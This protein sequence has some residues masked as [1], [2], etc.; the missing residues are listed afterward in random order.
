MDLPSETLESIIVVCDPADA[1]RL[2]QTSKVLHDLLHNPADTFC[3]RSLYLSQPLDDPRLCFT[4]TGMKPS[5]VDW[6]EDL[7]R[8]ILARNVLQSSSIPFG[9]HSALIRLQVLETLLNIAV[10]LPPKSDPHEASSSM[11]LSWVASQVKNG[12]LDVSHWSPAPTTPERQILARLYTYFAQVDVEAEFDRERST[13][14]SIIM[15][16]NNFLQDE[17]NRGLTY[18]TCETTAGIT[19]SDHFSTSQGE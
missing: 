4:L 8:F 6:K 13:V 11:N 12:L 14:I 1:A 2:S 19:P 10:H 18:T 17:S 16:T 7:E 15:I 9:R 3:W 5:D